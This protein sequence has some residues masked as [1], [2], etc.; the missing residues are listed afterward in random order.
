MRK[1]EN[2]PKRFDLWT[3]KEFRNRGPG[4]TRTYKCTIYYQLKLLVRLSSNTKLLN[5][6]SNRGINLFLQ[7]F[8]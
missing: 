1:N 6:R 2:E 3:G 5:K 7:S 8:G 4:I